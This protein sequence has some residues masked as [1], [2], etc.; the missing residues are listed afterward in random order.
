M[1]CRNITVHFKLNL[2]SQK[3][4]KLFLFTFDGRLKKASQISNFFSTTSTFLFL[5]FH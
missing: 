5:S 4:L 3:L 1:G 2:E